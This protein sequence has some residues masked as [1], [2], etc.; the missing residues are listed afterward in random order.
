MDKK[1][2][3]LISALKSG[4]YIAGIQILLSMVLYIFEVNVLNFITPILILLLTILVISLIQTMGGKAFRISYLEDEMT[5]GKAYL[6]LLTI[7]AFSTVFVGFYD[8]LYYSTAD[9][10]YLKPMVEEFIINL[11]NSGIPE[12]NLQEIYENTQKIYTTPP[13]QMAI[14]SMTNFMIMNA[15]IALIVAIFVK[16]KKPIFEEDE[17]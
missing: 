6:F 1:N 4:A 15:I 14:K 13:L 9:L 5:Y 10:S 16:K 8:F 2:V 12:D 11:E 3:F 7:G 17:F